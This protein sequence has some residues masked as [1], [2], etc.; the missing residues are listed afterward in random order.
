MKTMN[1]LLALLTLLPL[2]VAPASRTA[3]PPWETVKAQAE[4]AYAEGSYARAHEAYAQ[5]P[6]S[7]LPPAERRWVAFRLADTQWRSEAATETSDSTR[8]DQAREQLETI[9]R[10]TK[11]QEARDIVWAETNESLGDFWWLRNDSRNSSAALP[12]YQAA[13]D[14]WAGSRDID[15]AR[16]RYLSM[17]W[18]MAW[19]RWSDPSNY[20]GMWAAGVP[21]DILDNAATIA[22]EPR[23]IARAHYFL[24]LNLRQR[25]DLD[26]RDRVGDEFEASLAAGKTEWLDDALFFYAQW[27]EG[28][29]PV[30]YDDDGQWRGKADYVKAL[31][32]YRRLMS[33]YK[34]GESAYWEQAKNQ[35]DA[36]TRSDV[37]V[38]VSNFFIPG[39]EVS[40]NLAWRNLGAI[41]LSLTR[42]DLTRDIRLGTETDWLRSIDTARGERVRSWKKDGGDAG[43]HVPRSESVRLDGKLTPGAYVLEA[44]GNGAHA[45]E[46]I[47]VTDVALVL[48]TSPSKAVVYAANVDSGAPVASARVQLWQSYY[49][50]GG[51]RYASAG[52]TTNADGIAVIDLPRRESHNIFVAAAK[53]DRQA[54][55]GGWSY[56]SSSAAA[57]WRIYATTDRPAYRPDEKVQ[58]KFTARLFDGQ[59]YSTPSGTTLSY[60]VYDPRGAKVFEGTPKLN[61]FGSAWG[62]FELGASM[63]LGEYR[64]QFRDASRSNVI[65]NATLFRI[66]EYKLPEFRVNVTTSDDKGERK[67]Y[68]LGDRVTVNIEAEYYF[69]GPVASAAVEVV[70]YRQPYFHWWA[71]ARDFDWYATTESTRPRYY[72]G[73]QVVKRETLTTD[74]NGRASV[75]I[76]SSS[77]E[78]QDIEYRIEARVVD[79]SRREIV[80]EGRVRVTRQPFYAHLDSMRLLLRPGEKSRTE[81]TTIDANDQPV[82][83]SGTVRV[84]REQ[85]R[86]IW[87]DPAGREVSG[88]DLDKLKASSHRFPPPDQPGWRIRKQG[89]ESE[90]IL[91]APLKTDARGKAELT[92]TPE[93]EGYYR[94]AWR[95][96]PSPRKNDRVRPRSI[97]TAETAVWIATKATGELGYAGGGVEIIVDRDGFRAGRT[98]P[99]MITSRASDRWVLFTVEGEDIYEQR[100]VH[101]DGTVKVLELDIEEKHQPNVFLSAAMVVGRELHSDT[102]EIVVPPVEHFLD[103][104]V[105][106]DRDE[107]QPRDEGTLT[108]TAR[109][110]QGKPVAAEV[111]L[112]LVDE[113]I[114][115]IQQDYAGDPRPFFF[116][117]KKARMVQTTSSFSQKPYVRLEDALQAVPATREEDQERKDFRDA[118][119]PSRRMAQSGNVG[120]VAES[121]AMP[122]AAPMEKSVLAKTNE[123]APPPPPGGEAV[124]VRSDFRSTVLWQPDV[125]TDAA[126]NAVVKVR[127]PDSLT[128]WRATAR[129]ASRG[130]QFGIATSTARTKKPLIV[131]LQAPR[132]FLVGDRVTVSAVINNNTDAAMTVTSAIEATGLDLVAPAS[133][134]VSVAAGREARVDW[135][136][137][138]REPGEAMLRVKGVSGAHADA[139]EK[140]FTV[141]EHGIDKLIAR[142]GKMRGDEAVIRL[143]L[144]DARRSTEMFVD[145]TPSIAVT[146]LDAL[147]YLIQYPYGCTEQTMSRFLP[148]IIVARTLHDLHADPETV[149]ARIFGGI[150]PEHAGATHPNAPKNIDKLEDVTRAGLARL[151][152]FQHSDGGWG[153][154]KDGESDPFMTAYVVW[155]LTLAR[156][157]G[158]AIRDDAAARAATWLDQKLVEA[159]RS[160]DLQA[161]M[162]HAV[163]AHR[164]SRRESATSFETK[165]LDN[166]WTNR[167]RLNAYSRSLF[168]LSANIAG[169]KERAQALVRNLENGVKIDR[170]PDASIL[171]KGSGERTA[172]ATAHWGEDGLWWRWSDSPVESTS[173]ALR[174]LMAIDP[175]NELVE[176]VMNWLVKNRRGAQWSN[177]RDTAMAVLAL[178]EY[179]KRSGEMSSSV[180][181]EVSINGQPLGRKRITPSNALAAP[182][183][184][185]VPASAI[186]SNNEISIRKISGNAPLYFAA[187]ANFFSL[188]EPVRAAGSEMFVRRDY[189]RLAGH[190]TLLKGHVYDR[191]PLA[192]GASVKSGDRVEVVVTIDTKNDYEYLIFE[193][194]KP[195]GFEAI[196]VQS[197]KPLYAGE[198][199][200]GASA[201]ATS[202]ARSALETE[203]TGRTRWV[204]QELRDRKV[205][206]FV[207][208]LPQGVWQIRYTLR[209]EVPGAFHALPVI[210]QAMYVPEIRANGEEVRVK[211]VD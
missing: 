102:K 211:V 86:E 4:R 156:E 129:A 121:L 79:A 40:F 151:Y 125:R 178:D 200:S 148:A 33:E 190:P 5:I 50:G 105:K 210:G 82:S 142:S 95:S 26:A 43:D 115:S 117:T 81:L 172:L 73:D 158:V 89:Y 83:A 146:M 55:A 194:L 192:D 42:V 18:R 175:S 154:W 29:G 167:D 11:D 41:D 16:D 174:A 108:V 197:G 2:S 97:V 137:A 152:D 199:R 149:A 15:R 84:T 87:I 92:F 140:T 171:L 120:A 147:P 100:L 64:V 162:L 124:V 204:Y 107:Y 114:F 165:A 164:A 57:S 130:S 179:L 45:R 161:W 38:S 193:D 110:A 208:K 188:E 34:R 69:G 94:I 56:S 36:I 37:S 207:D 134:P 72:G 96:D 3:A 206:M 70:V 133:V 24:A 160:H 20:Y 135:T 62:A 48:K 180:E 49:D 109:D 170:A 132:F 88:R 58:W 77:S 19:P 153:W 66:E 17:V 76:D 39:S 75:T 51:T 155:G 166:L 21:V 14:W 104:D 138:V 46:L 186:R 111:S 101:L 185:A 12:Y 91:K 118:A 184:F 177:T 122:A 28:G 65:G 163:T 187:Q 68:Q 90:E 1:L 6:L 181:Y 116:G 202:G 169:Q 67:T 141:Y 139:M 157:A 106:A 71:P 168:A 150:E 25:G 13:L 93:R 196:D 60:E 198:L 203:L 119:A 209:A 7:E 53:N 99:V 63:P 9:L 201:R 103:I 54:I 10:E 80:G 189:F 35:I 123:P 136:V 47:L 74:E 8:V 31:E 127:Y 191:E 59:V 126:G 131:R 183:R 173:T 113:S 112:A 44:S 30:V 32:L 143:E 61:E 145:V 22:R 52:G 182:S 159:E 98:A 78:G 144:P 27:L 23:D 195:A 128:T 205:A 176:P 85:W